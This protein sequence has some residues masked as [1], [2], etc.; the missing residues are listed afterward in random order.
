MAARRGN[1]RRGVVFGK[2]CQYLAVAQLGPSIG[3]D[4]ASL[5]GVAPVLLAMLVLKQRSP[6]VYRG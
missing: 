1:H 6:R 2:F 4:A 3:F 5:L